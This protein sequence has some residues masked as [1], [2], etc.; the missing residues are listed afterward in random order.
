MA[1][2]VLEGGGGL[3]ALGVV[4]S[5]EFGRH[6]YWS[7]STCSSDTSSSFSD[8]FSSLWWTSCLGSSSPSWR[9]GP[10]QRPTLLSPRLPISEWGA[11]VGS[12]CI[13]GPSWWCQL[14][15]AGLLG[16]FGHKNAVDFLL[17]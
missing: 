6:G 16:R 10:H 17:G 9:P 4:V 13:F 15:Y 12:L 11:T 3:P 7:T 14:H 5:A 1:V 8:R 2:G